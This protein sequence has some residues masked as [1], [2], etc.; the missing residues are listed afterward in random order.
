EPPGLWRH[1]RGAARGRDHGF[2]V[3]AFAVA[4]LIGR[5]LQSTVH[6]CFVQTNTAVSFRFSFLCVQLVGFV[7]LIW[8][9]VT[10]LN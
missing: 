1:R 5:M 4:I 7:G 10:R 2:W 9:I 8:I 6:I 3:D